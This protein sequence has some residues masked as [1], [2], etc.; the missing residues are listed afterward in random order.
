MVQLDLYCD[1][2]YPQVGPK[3]VEVLSIYIT[4]LR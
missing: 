2:D 4:V 3:S 1:L